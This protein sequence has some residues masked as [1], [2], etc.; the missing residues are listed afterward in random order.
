MAC[1]CNKNPSVTLT[2]KTVFFA[3]VTWNDAGCTGGASRQLRW[4]FYVNGLLKYSTLWG[5]ATAPL[6]IGTGST[7]TAINAT[8]EIL[9]QYLRDQQAVAIESGDTIKVIVEARNCQNETA[10][11]NPVF[12]TADVAES[13]CDCEFE[14][15]FITGQT[16]DT[17]D[18]EGV[19]TNGILVFRNG[20]LNYAMFDFSDGELVV[21]DEVV[22]VTPVNCD[23][24]II[25]EEVTGESGT[26]P[27]PSS[28]SGLN[29][30]EYLL[31]RNGAWQYGYSQSAGSVAPSIA[32]SEPDDRWLFVRLDSDDGCRFGSQLVIANKTG[33]TFTLPA[34]YTASNQQDWILMRGPLLMHPDSASG[35]DVT[36]STVTLD[37]P[38]DGEDFRIIKFM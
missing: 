27:I 12:L 21:E 16:G 19:P 38:A 17:S 25:T 8:G 5:L 29:L 3:K 2:R 7:Y 11:S 14:T 6:P 15:F 37:V 26:V 4:H 33:S 28:F 9:T 30:G 22:F 35:Y 24:E 13:D 23:S 31:F 36:G 1:C 32:P 18:N 20:Q 34:G 10:F